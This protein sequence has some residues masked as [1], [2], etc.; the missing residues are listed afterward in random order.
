MASK[1]N[2]NL[3]KHIIRMPRQAVHLHHPTHRLPGEGL[4]ALLV[5]ADV[6]ALVD[7]DRWRART[8]M[9][10]VFLDCSLGAGFLLS[11]VLALG[12]T[13]GRWKNISL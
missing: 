11:W 10:P 1:S 6:S 2:E 12:L 5:R 3:N 9:S 4:R 13:H 7:V 8:I